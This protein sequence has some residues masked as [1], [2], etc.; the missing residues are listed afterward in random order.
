MRI[1][2]YKNEKPVKVKKTKLE[3]PNITDIDFKSI[4]SLV[5]NK[6]MLESM[7]QLTKSE[8]LNG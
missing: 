8:S 3:K 2:I 1:E 6:I 7:F 4:K 5:G